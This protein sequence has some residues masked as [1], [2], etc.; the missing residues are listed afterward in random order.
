MTTIPSVVR[1]A[2]DRY[3]ESVAVVDGDLRLTFPGLLAEAEAV[4]RG[5]IA[6]GVAVGDRVAIWAPN[7]GIWMVASMGVYMAGAVL[8][9]INTRY[10]AA[11]AEHVLRKSGAGMVLTVSDFGDLDYAAVLS[12]LPRPTWSEPVLLS[13]SPRPGTRTWAELLAAGASVP[14]KEVAAREGAVDDDSSSDII[15]TSGTTGAPKGAV[16]THGAS[17]RTYEVWAEKVGLRAG[18]RYLVLYPFFHTAGLKSGLLGSVIRG[19]TVYPHAVF[20]V[21]S[22][23]EKVAVERITVLPGTPT[24]FQSILNHPD[25]SAF[26]LSSVRLSVTGAAV[27]PVSIVRAMREQLGFETVVTG[28]GMT[29]TTGTISMCSHEDPPD[30]IAETVGRPLPGVE[31]RVVDDDGA[32]LPAG[33]AGEFWVR[34]FNVMKEYFDDPVA[35]ADSITPDGWL[36]TGDVGHIDPAGNLRI[37][38]RKKD[39]FI[40]GGFNAYPAEIEACL[41]GHPGIAQV[42]VVGVADERLGEVGA[43]FVV[44]VPGA[45]LDPDEVIAWTRR[46]LADFKVPRRVIVTTDLPLTPSGKV[47]KFELKKGLSK[48]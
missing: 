48:L 20:D 32:D 2:A 43:A 40:V 39:M 23:M 33:Q 22:V 38:D 45:E 1:Q 31:V 3:P 42:A 19:A 44:P 21:P 25:F 18:D 24:V 11:E 17:V 28:Y 13:G 30:V 9:P 47:M 26:D 16:L 7:S 35:T 6:S 46:R 4:A 41:L 36:K 34:G 27:V 29:E 12:E 15:F 14:D 8:V 37:T 5:L 10:R